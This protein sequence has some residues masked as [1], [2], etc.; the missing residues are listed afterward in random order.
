M[1]Y[2]NYHS[3]FAQQQQYDQQQANGHVARVPGGYMDQ[4]Y[5]GQYHHDAAAGHYEQPQQY[6]SAQPHAPSC[7][8]CASPNVAS[9]GSVCSRRCTWVAN[10]CCSQCGRMRGQSS[11]FC[12]PNCAA[13]ARQ[14]NWCIGCGVRQLQHGSTTCGSMDCVALCRRLATM[15][16]APRVGMSPAS[17]QP[18][19]FSPQSKS[20]ASLR[21]SASRGGAAPSAGHSSRR[22]EPHVPIPVS[23]KAAGSVRSVVGTDSAKRIAAIVKVGGPAEARKQYTAYRCRVESEM[24]QDRGIGAPKFGHGGEGNEHRRFIPLRSECGLAVVADG[25]P[26]CG[27]PTCEVC[28]LLE[29]GIH[30]TCHSAAVPAFS[31]VAKAAEGATDGPDASVLAVAVCRVTVGT[32]RVLSGSDIDTETGGVPAPA[33]HEHSTVVLH[34]G[35][36]VAYVPVTEHCVD[37]QF[38]VFLRA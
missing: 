4:L 35:Y 13:E 14:A 17:A 15:H 3:F 7:M 18:A 22:F 10:G 37:P 26:T 28:T 6:A 27:S 24:N 16:G 5:H 29:G 25:V 8:V 38:L 2:S 34:D 20:S 23:D 19:R 11:Y 36:D 1:Q 12:S 30:A 33:P 32:A 9:F 31:S 21:A